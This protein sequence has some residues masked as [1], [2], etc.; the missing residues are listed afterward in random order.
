MGVS[1]RTYVLRGAWGLVSGPPCLEVH[2][3]WYQDLCAWGCMGFGIRISVLRGARGLVLGSLC[4][5]VHGG[6]N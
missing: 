2:R 1:I 4:L 5:G 6:W 3:G